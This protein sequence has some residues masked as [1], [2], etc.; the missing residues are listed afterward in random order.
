[1]SEM[2]PR[3]VSSP[4]MEARQSND[5]TVNHYSYDQSQFTFE[6]DNITYEY[7]SYRGEM[8]PR[9]IGSVTMRGR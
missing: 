2:R 4:S 7:V 8:E 1:M 5:A 9:T 6:S 3:I